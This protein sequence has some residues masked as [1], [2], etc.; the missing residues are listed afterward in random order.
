MRKR[1]EY[2]EEGLAWRIVLVCFLIQAFA[3]FAKLL[4]DIFAIVG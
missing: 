4:I 2:E 1:S 3:Q